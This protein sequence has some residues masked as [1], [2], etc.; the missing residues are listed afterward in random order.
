MQRERNNCPFDQQ[1]PNM[2]KMMITD[3]EIDTSVY[4]SNVAIGGPEGNR[5]AL[6]DK[7]V[8][9]LLVKMIVHRDDNDIRGMRIELNNGDS[10]DVGR[11][12]DS[13]PVMLDLTDAQ[14]TNIVIHC[15]SSKWGSAIVKGININTSK[16]VKN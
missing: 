12:I 5:F 13:H 16:G 3:P 6:E 4:Q 11:L 1:T 10:K 8:Q 15:G 14:M 9:P 7:V 2:S